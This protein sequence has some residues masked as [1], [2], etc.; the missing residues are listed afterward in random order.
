MVTKTTF[1]T[2]RKRNG[3]EMGNNLEGK[4]EEELY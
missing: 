4:Y 3:G 1:I 2:N